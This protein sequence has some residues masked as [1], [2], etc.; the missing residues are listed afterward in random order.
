MSEIINL[1]PPPPEQPRDPQLTITPFDTGEVV[2]AYPHPKYP[3]HFVLADSAKNIFAVTPSA[4][5]A[6]LIYEALNGYLTAAAL[7]RKMQE[8]T[9]KRIITLSGNK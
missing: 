7:H 3:G 4:D 5:K 8:E 1:N 2:R 6:Q 9:K